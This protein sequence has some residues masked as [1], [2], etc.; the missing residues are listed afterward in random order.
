MILPTCFLKTLFLQVTTNVLFHSSIESLQ[1]PSSKAEEEW[2]I[3]NSYHGWW[4]MLNRSW[5]SKLPLVAEVFIWRVLIGGL[6]LGIALKRRGL[7]MGNCFFCIVQMEDNTHRFIQCPIACQIWSY[8]SQ[9]WQ[10]LSRCREENRP[11]VQT[12]YSVRK[13]ALTRGHTF[14][15]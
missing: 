4:H 8:I 12:V 2:K 6:P 10:V 14:V 13:P 5:H 11:Q 7:V 3:H 9:I 1:W 15:V